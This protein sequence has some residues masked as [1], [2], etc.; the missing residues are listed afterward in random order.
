MTQQL[1]SAENTPQWTRARMSLVVPVGPATREQQF[2]LSGGMSEET[3]V[4]PCEESV[5]IQAPGGPPPRESQ[6]AEACWE[7]HY[8][9]NG[10][11]SQQ[12]GRGKEQET[13][14]KSRSIPFI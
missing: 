1:P 4:Y 13:K 12:N 5:E 6:T 10:W 3:G 7:K 2:S 14:G 11:M 9:K 8:C